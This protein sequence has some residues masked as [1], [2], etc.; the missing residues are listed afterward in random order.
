M[1]VIDEIFLVSIFTGVCVL[2]KYTL[3][4]FQAL[5]KDGKDEHTD[6]WL[7]PNSYSNIFVRLKEEKN[8]KFQRNKKRGR[9][10]LLSLLEVLC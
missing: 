2:F 1:L 10:Q 8:M 6:Q 4:L 7:E 9:V 5:G 3:E